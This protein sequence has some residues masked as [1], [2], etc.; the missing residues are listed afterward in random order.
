[1]IAARI[2]FAT[3]GHHWGATIASGPTVMTSFG[4]SIFI[5]SLAVAK[6][7]ATTGVPIMP[8]QSCSD[9]RIGIR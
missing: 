8:N 9:R 4:F 3:I 2:G 7:A 1:M 6:R 5:E